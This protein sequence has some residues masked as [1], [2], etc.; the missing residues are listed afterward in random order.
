MH[1]CVASY[2]QNVVNGRS[3]IYS[4]RE[5]GRRVAT[6]EVI[7]RLTQYKGPKPQY[8]AL[9]NVRV[10]ATVGAHRLVCTHLYGA[11]SRVSVSLIM[12]TGGAKRS[13]RHEPLAAVV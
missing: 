7:G 11:I 3:R 4:I 6:L 2:W 12:C 8:D 10:A 9:V 1:H 13:F 5:T